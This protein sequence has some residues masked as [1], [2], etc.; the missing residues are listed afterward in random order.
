VTTVLEAELALAAERLAR[1]GV[2]FA[3]VGGLAVSVRGEIRFTRDIDLAVLCASDRDTERLAADLA[4]AGYEIAALVEHEKRGRLSTVRL[5]S[6]SRIYV[7]LLAAS[8]GIEGEVIATATVVDIPNVGE[9]RVARAEELLV[10]KVL[11]MS[12]ARPQDRL[13]ARGLILTNPGLDLESVRARLALIRDRGFDRD[14]DLET[15]LE[16]VLSSVR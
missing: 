15:K 12:D 16:A 5:R 10:T 2:P 8:S 9:L 7:D 6:R 14:E 1:L 4:A 11:S 13:D 3:L